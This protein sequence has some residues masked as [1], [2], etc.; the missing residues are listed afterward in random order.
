LDLK[1]SKADTPNKVRLIATVYTA[2]P[3]GTSISNKI[4]LV[5]DYLKFPKK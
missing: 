1:N 4:N 5:A 2:E 3:L